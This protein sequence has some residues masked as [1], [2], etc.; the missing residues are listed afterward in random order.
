MEFGFNAAAQRRSLLNC[1]MGNIVTFRARIMLNACPQFQSSLTQGRIAAA[2]ERL[3]RIR[4]VAPISRAPSETGFPWPCRVKIPSGISIG[5][6]VVA[7]DRP[8]D[9]QTSQQQ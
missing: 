9:R 5:S 3:K 2:R 7:G 4:H 8:T 6:A 1:G